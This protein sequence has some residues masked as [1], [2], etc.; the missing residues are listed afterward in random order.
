MATIQSYLTTST[1]YPG[2]ADGE[3]EMLNGVPPRPGRGEE[4]SQTTTLNGDDW[5]SPRCASGEGWLIGPWHRAIII[6]PFGGGGK[7]GNFTEGGVRPPQSDHF[8]DQRR[9][10]RLLRSSLRHTHRRLPRSR[11]W[12]HRLTYDGVL[13]SRRSKAP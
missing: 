9:I 3:S 13:S 7:G 4:P 10:R 6:P 5:P 11:T 12:R 2:A 8:P 1:A